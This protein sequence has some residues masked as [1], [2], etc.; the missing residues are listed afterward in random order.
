MLPAAVSLPLINTLIF[1]RLVPRH[2][3]QP[4]DRPPPTR[5]QVGRFLAGDYT[6]ALCVLAITT[7]VPVTVAARVDPK[8]NAYFYMAWVIG[9]TLDLFAVNMATSLTVEGAFAPTALA[10]GC[11]AA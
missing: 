3:S 6:G 9:A 5:R 7:L 1:G 2:A 10:A 11:R 8:M 4:G